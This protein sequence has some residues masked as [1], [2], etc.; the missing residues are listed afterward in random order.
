LVDRNRNKR[1]KGPKRR[2][3]QIGGTDLFWGPLCSGRAR[4]M[5]IGLGYGSIITAAALVSSAA[6][7]GQRDAA[8]QEPAA[9]VPAPGSLVET[10]RESPTYR[11]ASNVITDVATG[12]GRDCPPG[13]CPWIAGTPGRVIRA[14][15]AGNGGRCQGWRTRRRLGTVLLCIHES[16]ERAP[17]RNERRTNAAQGTGNRH[18]SS[19][20]EFR[21]TF[22]YRYNRHK[23]WSGF[24]SGES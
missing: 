1:L 19:P 22:S 10:G 7:P 4:T 3:I 15:W 14:A 2:Q 5:E 18:E 12:I 17:G 8:G 6:G 24:S 23:R 21:P 20:C 11:S 13:N 9:I 16:G